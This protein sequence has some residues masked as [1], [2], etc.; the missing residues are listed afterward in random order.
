[1]GRGELRPGQ[2]AREPVSSPTQT[3]QVK[4][5]KNFSKKQRILET[6]M[7]KINLMK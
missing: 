2:V 4:K 3:S 6:R 7:S 1:M 5:Y